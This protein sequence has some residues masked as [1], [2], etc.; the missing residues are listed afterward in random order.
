MS[1]RNNV[2]RYFGPFL[3]G[4]RRSTMTGTCRGGQPWRVPPL[5][6]GISIAAAEALQSF[7]LKQ[8]PATR[9]PTIR[10]A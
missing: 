5:I 4:A 6:W 8:R 1:V 3:R 9:T 2:V 7:L 10:V